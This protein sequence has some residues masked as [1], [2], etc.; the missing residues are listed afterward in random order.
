MLFLLLLLQ[1]IRPSSLFPFDSQSEKYESN[2]QFMG[3]L[4]WGSVNKTATYI[5]QHKHRKNA[6]IHPCLHWDSNP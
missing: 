3:L 6:N 1:W 5:G 4:E 2:G